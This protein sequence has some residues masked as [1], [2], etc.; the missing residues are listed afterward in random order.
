MWYY[1]RISIGGMKE[2]IPGKTSVNVAGLGVETG[3]R[4]L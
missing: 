2:T 1:I 4:D 3:N